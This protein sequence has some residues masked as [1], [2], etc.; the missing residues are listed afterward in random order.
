ME[1]ENETVV[2]TGDWVLTL[3]LTA[4]PIVNI[5]MLFV[6]AFGLAT[7]PSKANWAKATLIWAAVG[8][9]L[10]IIFY[11]I[12]GAAFLSAFSQ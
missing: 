4:I 1:H 9:V 3:L 2:R 5:I 11:A 12:F 6:W 7:P 10:Y 8:I